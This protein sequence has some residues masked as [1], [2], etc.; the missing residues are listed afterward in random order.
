MLTKRQIETAI[1][2]LQLAISDRIAFVDAYR[3]TLRKGLI[4]KTVCEI[5]SYR[6]L[7]TKMT[8]ELEKLNPGKLRQSEKSELQIVKRKINDALGMIRAFNLDVP[9]VLTVAERDLTEA[10]SVIGKASECRQEGGVK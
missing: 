4:Y 8:Q 2:G 6:R 7:M 1:N 9:E 5:N 10:L 3:H